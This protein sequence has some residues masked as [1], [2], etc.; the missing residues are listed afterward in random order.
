MKNIN[1]KIILMTSIVWIVPIFL[2]SSMIGCATSPSPINPVLAKSQASYQAA[3]DNP[4]I[5]ENAAV[6]LYEAKKTL[7]KAAKAKDVKDIEREANRAERQVQ[8]A[9]AQTE[10][11]KAE[12]KIDVLTKENETLLLERS[13]RQTDQQT[14]EAN[15]ARQLAEQKVKEAEK[16]REELEKLQKELAGLQ[17]KQTDRGLVLT[18]RDVLF[19]FGKADLEPGAMRTIEKVAEFLLK[20]PQRNVLIEGHTDNVGGDGFNLNLSERRAN[21]VRTALIDQAVPP[22]RI[23]IKGY[24]KRLPVANNDT[25]SGRQQNRRVEIVILNEGVAA[26]LLF[27]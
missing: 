2:M 5:E 8:I 24:G 7:D 15:Q 27:R 9:I 16:A 12:Q 23:T 19:E 1:R 17:A 13:R 22:E 6:A 25:E 10:Q 20:N 26:E 14:L 21:S 3:K 4:D 18:L 11:K